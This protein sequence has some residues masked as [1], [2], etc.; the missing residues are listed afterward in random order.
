[1]ATVTRQID[2][3]QLTMKTQQEFYEYLKNSKGMVN[4]IDGGGGIMGKTIFLKFQDATFGEET[5][6]GEV[7]ADRV[8]NDM[9][10]AFSQIHGFTAK[11]TSEGNVV[12][13]NKTL[14]KYLIKRSKF[15]KR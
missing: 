11:K 5:M 2:T 1:M 10:Q 13:S 4:F 7:I 14:N 15:K 12:I 3:S 9:V 6:L 8:I